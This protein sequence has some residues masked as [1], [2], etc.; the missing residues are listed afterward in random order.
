M[1]QRQRKTGTMKE[2]QSDEQLR[3]LPPSFASRNMN[4][5]KREILH[6]DPPLIPA[7]KELIPPN[8]TVRRLQLYT[9]VYTQDASD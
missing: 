6:F 2:R 3:H 8:K 4:W 9:L 7:S 5:E 1:R